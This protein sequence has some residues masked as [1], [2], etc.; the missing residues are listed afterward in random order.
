MTRRVLLGAALILASLSR[1]NCD[2]VFVI[3]IPPVIREPFLGCFKGPITEPAGAG[4]VTIVLENPPAGDG[5][6]LLGCLTATEPAFDAT[7]AGMV[8]DDRTQARFAVMPQGGRPSFVLL[9]TRQ[10]AEG[11]AMTLTL[12]NESDTPFKSAPDLPRCSPT[13]TCA[14]LGLAQAFVPEGGP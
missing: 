2:K 13:L 11:N 6:S 9:V 10:P 5:V 8:L 14:D 4:V 1:L 7:M 12:V 3:N